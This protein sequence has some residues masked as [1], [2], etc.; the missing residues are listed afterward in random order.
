VE[1]GIAA[2]SIQG[3]FA[4]RFTRFL[5][6]NHTPPQNKAYMRIVRL[7]ELAFFREY[8][9][10]IDDN[11]L[12]LGSNFASTNSDFY[13]NPERRESYGCIVAN[14]SAMRYSFKDGRKLFVSK[15]TLNEGANSFL[16]TTFGSLEQCETVNS[17]KRFDSPHT[18]K[19]IGEWLAAEHKSKGLLPQYVMYHCTDGASNAVASF[20]TYEMITELNRDTP[21]EHVKCLAHQT[22]RSA[23]YAS[24]TGDFRDN[25][26]PRLFEVLSKCHRIVARVHRSSARIKVVKDVQIQANRNKAVLPSP[27]VTTRWD[28]ANREVAS[29]NRIMGDFNRAL[30][31]LINGIDKGKLTPKDGEFVP[32]TDYT[33][34]PNDKMILAQFECGSEPC[35]L[36][37]KFF[38]INDATSH[39]TI[40]VTGAYLALMG[41]T[42]F[43]MFHDISH[44][45]LTDLKNRN[46]TV[47]VISSLHV[48]SDEDSG[49]T[50]EVMDPCIELYRML[51]LKD[52]LIRCGFT[53][54]NG[55][56]CS[57]LPTL[58]AIALLLNPL[59]GCKTKITG[60][61]LMTDEQYDNALDDL[62]ARMQLMMERE[63]GHMEPIVLSGG[64]SDDSMDDPIIRNVSTERDQAKN[65]FQAYCNVVKRK[66]Y[67]PKTYE[68]TTL[69]LGKIQM[70]RVATRGD[71]IKVSGNFVRCNLADFIDDDG[72]FDLVSFLKLQKATFP[73]LYK[74]AVCLASIRSNEVGCERFFST[75]GYVSCPRRTSLKVRNYECLAT[76]KQ[77]M[78]N[79]YIDEDWVVNQYLMMEQKKSWGDLDHEDDML[80]L[81][82]ERQ[83]LAESIGV[84]PETL[85]ENEDEI[86]ETEVSEIMDDST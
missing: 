81:D 48:M 84:D 31:I 59:Y 67:C 82:L 83:M 58:T 38:Q 1:A 4:K 86:T 19:N 71:D 77:N 29:V 46:K 33:F 72:H 10:L 74:L 41:S 52:M 16:A 62:I 60:N 20:N 42:T 63:S 3:A 75:A 78:R 27:G 79:V 7:L 35:V 21:I 8:K 40:F 28:S 76:L 57:K 61:G 26:N 36:L 22:N 85:L 2:I 37:S 18:G 34:T 69:R 17:F 43:N 54:E 45:D 9:R 56:P 39:E 64:D 13:S 44:S 6:T 55:D 12:W 11:V 53:E 65:E 66:C 23:K 30:H 70:G 14:M 51:Y 50:F 73:T 32:I 24:G 68:G 49:R 80:V 5:D 47:Y 25:A 15:K